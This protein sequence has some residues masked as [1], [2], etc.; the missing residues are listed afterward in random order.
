MI[1][2]LLSSNGGSGSWWILL[3]LV[4][5]LVIMYIISFVRRK[6]YNQQTVDMLE[7]L[8]P[9]DKIKTYS[10]IYGTIVSIRETT[11]G[12]VVTIETGDEKH[13]SYTSIDSN[14][15]Y[16]IDKKEDIVYDTNGNIIEPASSTDSTETKENEDVKVEQ[17]DAEVTEENKTESVENAEVVEQ[18]N[19][20]TEANEPEK[21]KKSR[22]KNN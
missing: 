4:A 22:K 19:A 11:D 16:C 12:K 5:V 13:K 10:G 2:N 15:I 14:A 21:K 6:K 3:I 1:S 7:S 8:K 9:G 18:E 17:T 20:E